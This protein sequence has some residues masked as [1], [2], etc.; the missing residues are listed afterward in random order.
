MAVLLLILTLVQ[1]GR[2]DV[3]SAFGSGM[4]QTIF[5]VGGVETILTKATYWLGGV[6]LFLAVLLSVVPKGERGPVVAGEAQ[7]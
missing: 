4:G 7:V 1:K 2:G 5:G 6:F 3:G